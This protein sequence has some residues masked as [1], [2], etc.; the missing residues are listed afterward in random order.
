MHS[1]L[2]NA[3]QDAG[4][5]PG[6]PAPSS[7]V[8]IPRAPRG[9]SARAHHL[10]A[11]RPRAAHCAA[12]APHAAGDQPPAACCCLL[13]RLCRAARAW[14]RRPGGRRRWPR[15]ARAWCARRPAMTSLHEASKS[16]NLLR[17]STLLNEGANVHATD[18]DGG[19]QALHLACREGHAAVVDALLAAGARPGDVSNGGWTSLHCAAAGAHT[20]VVEQLLGLGC[21]AAPVSAEGDTPMHWAAQAGSADVMRLL[22]SAGAPP[23]PF[24]SSGITPLHIAAQKGHAHLVDE[25]L[26][27]GGPGAADVADRGQSTPLHNAAQAG[28]LE[29]AELL[30]AAG[31]APNAVSNVRA[32]RARARRG[33]SVLR[34]HACWAVRRVRVPALRR[35]CCAPHANKRNS[36]STRELRYAARPCWAHPTWRR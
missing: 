19:W 4:R 9:R 12:H 29:V 13:V 15:S 20:H 2:A 8:T 18:G 32:P 23:L 36:P 28:H 25:L 35:A 34:V 24:N 3:S 10:R 27:A 1:T 14:H 30:L 26:R 33:R 31:A 5:G 7:S 6:S 17:L 11:P 21:N 16:N 22:L